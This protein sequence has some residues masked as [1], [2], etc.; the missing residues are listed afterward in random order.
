VVG[1][2][3]ID[4]G[5]WYGEGEVKVYRDGDVELP[6]IC[7]TGLEDYVGTAWGMAGHAAHYAGV[8]LD[9]KPTP[10]TQM[11]DFVGF[12]RWHVLDPIMFERD[13]KVTIQQIGYDAFVGG[14]GARLDRYE[15]DGLVAGNGLRRVDNGVVLAHGIVERQDDYCAVAFTVCRDAQPVP[16]VDVAGAIADIGRREYEVA[17]P[18][19]AMLM[20]LAGQH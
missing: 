7:G 9:V 2:R 8:A 1:I 13:I 16:R 18:M 12:Y 20:A 6:T 17:S 4:G 10:E 5:V 3:V 11:P 19:E 14:D 15:R